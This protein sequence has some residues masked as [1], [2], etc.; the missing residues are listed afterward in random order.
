MESDSTT[1]ERN[2]RRPGWIRWFV[3]SIVD[4]L[5][6][7]LVFMLACTNLSSR[8]LGDAGIGWHIRTGQWILANHAIPHVDP[9]SSSLYGHPWF[10]WEW[11]FDVIA[12]AL[13]AAAGLNGVVALAAL[14]IALTFSLTL[15]LLVERGTNVVLGLI[16]TLL[17]ISASMIHF[18][19]RPHVVSW[20]MAVIWFWI[21]DSHEKGSVRWGNNSVSV[22]ASRRRSELLWLL[23]ATMLFWVNMH[24]GFLLGFILLAIYWLGAAWDFVKSGSDRFESALA[25]IQAAQRL[26]ELTLVGVLSALATLINP[27]GLK[28]H[29]H[30]YD[31]L[32]NR[33]LIDHID[34]FQSP[35]FHLVA[36]KCF[37]VL[38]LLTII[39]AAAR[40]RS[41]T[42]ALTEGLVIIFAAYSGLY[43]S[44]NIPVSSLLLILVIGPW[45]SEALRLTQSA[46]LE[47]YSHSGRYT[48]L[49]QRIHAIDVRGHLWP[50]AAVLGL[51]WMVFHG[52]VAGG[53]S[54]IHAQFSEK[55]FP[56]AAAD[57]I[58]GQNLRGPLFA[59][60]FW[61]GYL[62][63]R[64]YPRAKVVID[65][66]HDFYGEAFLKSYLK[67]IHV[68]PG[69][70]DFLNLHPAQFLIVPRGSALANILAE[71]A[72]WHAVYSD[73]VAVV[74]APTS[75]RQTASMRMRP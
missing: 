45:L 60:D 69:W 34:E 14:L 19:A 12:G 20:L 54:Y 53:R 1:L 41:R 56:V 40:S 8:L 29:V 64:F 73:E 67:T 37:A 58:E 62:I 10:A 36:Q 33:F 32:S 7:A 11:L 46:E 55:R 35:N 65:D 66:R 61:G 68:E 5:F 15:Q 6:V 70:R 75:E 24:G 57:Y 4:V 28:L 48:R 16:L 49:L 27:Y 17:A 22:A 43:A 26:K 38:L 13:D 3:P 42:S 71:T 72:A 74:Y 9:F 21:L 59:P 23:P 39:A 47:K 31:Y 30:I 50:V 25:R 51:A 2:N 44:R 52:G 18:F 63:Y